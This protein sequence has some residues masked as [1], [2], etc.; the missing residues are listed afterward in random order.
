M[1]S[2]RKSN[3]LSQLDIA[4]KLNISVT[5]YNRWENGVSFPESDSIEK[6]ATIYNIRSTALFYDPDLDKP[7]SEIKDPL[8]KK[9][10]RRKLE[11]LIDMLK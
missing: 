11:E 8:N 10:I 9:E 4:N 2:I 3:G 5:T 1:E 6:L 7:S